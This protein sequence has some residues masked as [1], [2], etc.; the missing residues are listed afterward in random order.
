MKRK[1]AKVID[2][3]WFDFWFNFGK[4]NWYETNMKLGDVY[5]QNKII[6][7]LFLKWTNAK[8]FKLSVSIIK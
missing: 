8:K 1:L 4:N 6:K 7:V 5:L 3:I 2:M